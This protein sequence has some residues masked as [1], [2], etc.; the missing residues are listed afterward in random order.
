MDI[1]LQATCTAYLPVKGKQSQLCCLCR[2]L[3][4]CQ[5][6]VAMGF[7]VVWERGQV[8]ASTFSTFAAVTLFV[9]DSAV[10]KMKLPTQKMCVWIHFRRIV[11]S[12]TLLFHSLLCSLVPCRTSGDV[13]SV[14]GLLQYFVLLCVIQHFV[15]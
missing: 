2:I 14:N 4:E 9:A 10:V 8:K 1:P 7:C 6:N 15:S 11:H 5:G 12:A 3:L 13:A